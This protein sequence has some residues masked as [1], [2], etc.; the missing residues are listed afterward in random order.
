MKTRIWAVL[1]EYAGIFVSFVK[2]FENDIAPPP[3]HV[4]IF[5]LDWFKS[6]V[7]SDCILFISM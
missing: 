2:D 4:L 3:Q 6:V 5:Y 7:N 1:G